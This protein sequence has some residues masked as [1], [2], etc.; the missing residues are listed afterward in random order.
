M[1]IVRVMPLTKV[2]LG[3]LSFFTKDAVEVGQV[4][5]V[6]VRGKAVPALVSDARDAREERTAIRGQS[7]SLKKLTVANARRVFAPSVIDAATQIARYHATTL[8]AV[9]QALAPAAV[10][11]DAGVDAP[12]DEVTGTTPPERLVLQSEGDERLRTYRNITREAFAHGQSVMILAPSAPE[13]EALYKKLSRGIDEQVMLATSSLSKRAARAAWRR[14]ATDPEPLLIIATGTYL[15]L[16]RA[17]IA[18]LIVER[19]SARGYV[20]RER[21]QLDVRIMAEAVARARRAR[22]ILAD[23]PLRIE[24][25]VAKDAGVYEEFERGQIQ[26]RGGASVRVIDVRAKK[27]DPSIKTLG[28]KKKFSPLSDLAQRAIT[29]KTKE[30]GRVFVYTARKGLAPL[31]VCHDC[32]TPVTD[33]ATGTPMTLEKS[34]A[35]NVFVSHR[36]G[37]IIPAGTPCAVCGG[38]NLVT[39]GVAAQ[40]VEDELRTLFPTV[41]IFALTADSA[42]THAQAKKIR[43]AFFAKTGVIMVGTDR[44]LPYL[45]EPVELSVVA[46]LDSMLSI[47]AWR[48]HEHALHTLFALRERTAD[49]LIVQTRLP[50]ER[51]IRAIA[52]GNPSEFIESEIAE[53]KQFSYPPFATFVG[54]SWSG[55]AA[56][57]GK[58]S[59]VVKEALQQ[60][61]LVG[62]LPARASGKNRF[63]ARAVLRLPQGSWPDDAVIAAIHTLPPDISVSVDPDDIV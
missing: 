14:A 13:A 55:T 37:A 32:G 7:F 4:V 48:A 22:L 41:P 61:D 24:T 36:S 58:T 49:E 26:V 59:L 47:S 53:R 3:E 11:A 30:G 63:E 50:D 42:P 21:P 40:G 19:E 28:A 16:P 12:V 8:G 10:L 52:T 2:R 9:L 35:G 38:W 46:S 25:R 29:T 60:W 57:V 44:A 45:D 20:L 6:T 18:T 17:N 15:A 56:A 5:S 43:G 51:V 27:E 33:P 39:L 54:L 23:F 1:H 62:P 31:T 34:V